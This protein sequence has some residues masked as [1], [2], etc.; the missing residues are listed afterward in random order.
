MLPPRSKPERLLSLGLLLA[1]LGHGSTCITKDFLLPECNERWTDLQ[2]E[3]DSR[4][5]V[6]THSTEPVPG[7]SASSPG[8][9]KNP[10]AV[11][12]PFSGPRTAVLV[13]APWTCP[14]FQNYWRCSARSNSSPERGGFNAGAFGAP[15]G[16]QFTRCAAIRLPRGQRTATHL[17]L[18]YHMIRALTNDSQTFFSIAAT[19]RAQSGS[20]RA[21]TDDLVKK[22]TLRDVRVRHSAPLMSD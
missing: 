9:Y 5:T 20:S 3:S 13:K 10:P 21:N 12:G 14:N 4:L 2:D 22:V 11:T 15:D 17:S 1:G 16:S 18:T 6:P 8:T 19:P 7:T